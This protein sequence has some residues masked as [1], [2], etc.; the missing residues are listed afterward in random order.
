MSVASAALGKSHSH[1]SEITPMKVVNLLNSISSE[2]MLW[3]EQ[4][5]TATLSSSPVSIIYHRRICSESKVHGANMWS[6]WVLP[7]LDGPH[8]GPM[9]LSIRVVKI[10]L[11]Q[12]KTYNKVQIACVIFGEE[13]RHGIWKLPHYQSFVRALHRSLTDSPHKVPVIRISN[14]P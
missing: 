12:R 11:N 1:A 3:P 4:K 6:T 7:A 8:V 13:W 9:N 2:L 5:S 14:V 10:S